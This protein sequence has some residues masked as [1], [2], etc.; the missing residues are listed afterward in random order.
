MA[1]VPDA[2]SAAVSTWRAR[3]SSPWQTFA[4]AWCRFR[5]ETSSGGSSCVWAE[6]RCR[7]GLA[8]RM[9]WVHSPRWNAAARLSN[10]ARPY[11][12]S[13]VAPPA[14]ATYA[15]R[16]GTNSRPGPSCIDLAGGRG[17]PRAAPAWRTGQLLIPARR[18]FRYV[19]TGAARRASCICANA[20]K[21]AR[22]R[23]AVSGASRGEGG[24]DAHAVAALSVSDSV[25][26]SDA[27]CDSLTSWRPRNASKALLR[28][29]WASCPGGDPRLWL[30]GPGGMPLRPA[31]PCKDQRCRGTRGFA[32]GCEAL[33]NKRCRQACMLPEPLPQAP[34]L[35]LRTVLSLVSLTSVPC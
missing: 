11:L 6:E 32:A 20:W 26:A 33:D 23:R 24:G 13:L 19:A 14:S 21:T 29:G 10:S 2:S 30:A 31:C 17:Q 1:S 34:S 5:S 18:G 15:A 16:A 4:H 9:S 28:W 27:G 3:E 35:F 25:S 12:A 8:L 22:R 7:D